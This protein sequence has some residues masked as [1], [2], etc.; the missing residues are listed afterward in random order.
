MNIKL[1]V[2]PVYCIVVHAG[3][4]WRWWIWD[5]QFFELGWHREPWHTLSEQCTGC[6]YWNVVGSLWLTIIAAVNFLTGQFPMPDAWSSTRNTF[7]NLEWKSCRCCFN[8]EIYSVM[9]VCLHVCTVF[10]ST[11]CVKF[12]VIKPVNTSRLRSLVITTACSQRCHTVPPA[13]GLVHLAARG[14]A[15]IV[16]TTCAISVVDYWNLP[17]SW[18]LSLQLS[19]YFIRSTI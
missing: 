17:F 5:R 11:G 14:H 8:W 7:G 10:N 9:H 13:S 19:H 15:P 16:D 6:K 2:I 4:W 3:L 12:C 1:C 18:T